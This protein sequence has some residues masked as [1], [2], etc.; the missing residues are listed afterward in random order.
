MA[1][2][3]RRR[4]VWVWKESACGSGVMYWGL[5][6][7][8][9]FIIFWYLKYFEYKGDGHNGN[10]WPCRPVT[11]YD[12]TTPNTWGD[13]WI[14]GTDE[15]SGREVSQCIHPYSEFHHCSVMVFSSNNLKFC[16]NLRTFTNT[17]SSRIFNVNIWKTSPCVCSACLMRASLLLW[18][19]VDKRL[20]NIG[21]ILRACLFLHKSVLP[22][23]RTS[24]GSI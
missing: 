11:H 15:P 4:N 8:F 7:F 22:R 16:G 6:W 1:E 12:A 20:S 14:C 2:A 13:K 9:Y 19:L 18:L 21:K 23:L 10:H 5:F 24:C 17:K 3:H